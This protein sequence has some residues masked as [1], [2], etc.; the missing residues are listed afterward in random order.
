MHLTLFNEWI[1]YSFTLTATN[2]LESQPP[3]IVTAAQSD[4]DAPLAAMLPPELRSVDVKEYFPEF[5]KN[6]VIK[7]I[8][9]A[10][11]NMFF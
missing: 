4:H 2:G 10:M 7:A 9:Q 11:F 5:R 3:G 8:Q 6:K 1:E